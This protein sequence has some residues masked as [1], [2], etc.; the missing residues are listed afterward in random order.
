VTASTSATFAF[1]DDD[2]TVSF[3]CRLD[4]GAFALC[5][6][7][8]TY[9][10]LGEGSHTFRVKAVDP[11]GNESTVT[12]YS[13]YID[14]TNPVVT[15]D[16][17]SEPPDPTNRTSA[18]FVFTSN[19]ANSTFECRLDGGQFAACTSPQGYSG[20]GNARHT[21]GVRATDSLGHQGLETT[22]EWTVD[23]VA[24]VTTITSGPPATTESRL[25]TFVFAS[26]E[27]PATFACSLDGGAFTSCASPKTYGGLTDGAHLFAVRA[28]DLAGNMDTSPASYSWQVGT[29]TPP[30]TTPPGTVVDLRRTVGYR[31]LRLTWSPPTDAD[32]DH[33]QVLRSRGSK[34]AAQALVYE[35]DAG[36][37]TDARF[38][39]GTY[40]RY[41]IRTYDHVGN[42]SVGVAVVVPPSA[43]LRS[44]RNGAVVRVPPLMSWA[45][46][47][48]ATYY[49]VQLYRGSHKVL[50]AW[51]AKPRTKLHRTWVYNG[52]RFRLKKGAYHWFVWPA[53]GPRSKSNYGRLLGA[54]TFRVR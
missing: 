24:P 52:H 38:Q 21:F 1:T 39:N 12:S 15:I 43:L 49:N 26:S 7:P 28:T 53:F 22:Y 10:G 6:S 44:P 9:D 23:T 42:V 25:A 4:G 3:R 45:K 37:Y 29:Q 11:A 34:G 19:K 17:A 41:E 33:V 31:R 48:N 32:F 5:T 54:G 51:P 14:L 50:S 18:S 40:Y 27:S 8:I 16:P 36:S 47:R 35:G 20:L 30:D 13:W 2:G 46:V